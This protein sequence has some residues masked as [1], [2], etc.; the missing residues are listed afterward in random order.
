MQRRRFL[1][2][3]GAAVTLGLA[4]CTSTGGSAGSDGSGSQGDAG[5]Q[6]NRSQGDAGNANTSSARATGAR[7]PAVQGNTIRTLDVA[8]SPGGWMPIRPDE[9]ALL[10]FWATWCAPCKP[11]MAE[12]RAVHESFPTTHMLSIT[13]ERNSAA[14]RE[15]WR[16]YDGTWA[17]AQDPQLRTNERFGVTRVPTLLVFDAAG[18]EVWRHVGLAAADTIAAELRAAGAEE[19]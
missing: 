17:V 5:S 11:Q 1:A 2:G 8:G 9:P 19:R 13:N 6:G 14:V 3:V 4:G 12:L 10:D 15:F 7:T 16:E 18:N